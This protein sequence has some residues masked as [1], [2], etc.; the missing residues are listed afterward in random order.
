[1]MAAKETNDRLTPRQ[2]TFRPIIAA[3]TLSGNQ[4]S[5]A[6]VSEWVNQLT[7]LSFVMPNLGPDID[8]L[9]AKVI[10]WRRCQIALLE[11]LSQKALASTAE[12]N[13]FATS[14]QDIELAFQLARSC[15][16]SLEEVLEKTNFAGLLDAEATAPMF[17]SC[18]AAWGDASRLAQQA[19]I[20]D[21]K[22]R[23]LVGV[24]DMIKVACLF[25]SKLEKA[26]AVKRAENS[27]GKHTI[28]CIGQIYSEVIAQL[29]QL[30]CTSSLAHDDEDSVNTDASVFGER[31]A[32]VERLLRLYEYYSRSELESGSSDTEVNAARLRFFKDVLVGCQCVSAS[33]DYGHVLRICNFI[34]DSLSWSKDYRTYEFGTC[35][36]ISSIFVDIAL[37][38]GKCVKHPM[39]RK[40]VLSK[41]FDNASQYFDH[42]E[43][44][45]LSLRVD[46]SSV[47]GGMRLALV[48]ID[49]AESFL[50]SFEERPPMQRRVISRRHSNRS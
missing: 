15:C 40:R 19:G 48:G 5:P 30:D 46:R 9:A 49:D 43:K 28:Q 39:E 31:I 34:I 16:K 37:I 1:M 36:D 3:W 29:H 2:Q 20:K 45:D 35:D 14:D 17:T 8:T 10:V 33:S 13:I 32:D 44:T 47:I 25:D 7:Q 27:C 23:P 6:R 11:Q 38:A 18:I 12:N 21:G 4:S 24:R 42:K 26:V 22:F 50:T 41:I